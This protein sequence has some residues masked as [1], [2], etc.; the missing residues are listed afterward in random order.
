MSE[1]KFSGL[2]RG[3]L[4]RVSER[5]DFGFVANA[6]PE[7]GHQ[8]EA[9]HFDVFV[10]LSRTI[11]RV[12]ALKGGMWASFRVQPS[13]RK[14]GKWEA[15]EVIILPRFIGLLE[16]SRRDDFGF[17]NPSLM[18][19]YPDRNWRDDIPVPPDQSVFV[20]RQSSFESRPPEFTDGV[21]ISFCVLRRTV[22][23]E[24]DGA[25]HAVGARRIIEETTL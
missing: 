9:L 7:Y 21:L 25:L 6:T 16:L 11:T 14:E 18:T 2:Y 10:H 4:Q 19:F 8:G 12:A 20:H 13:A 24:R 15:C 23:G 3:S 5:G 17:I 1:A 22:G